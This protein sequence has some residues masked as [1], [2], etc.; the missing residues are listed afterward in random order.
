M[1]TSQVTAAIWKL[2]Q[3]EIPRGS[4]HVGFGSKEL[5]AHLR[6][7]SPLPLAALQ[8]PRP[9]YCCLLPADLKKAP[10]S[11]LASVVLATPDPDAVPCCKVFMTQERHKD[12]VDHLL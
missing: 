10:L 3:D 11:D 7:A 9:R 6:S 5:L 12:I 4:S 1:M 8:V 2:L